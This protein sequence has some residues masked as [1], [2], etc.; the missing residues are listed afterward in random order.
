MKS[1]ALQ[2]D[3]LLRVSAAGGAEC[4]GVELLARTTVLL[5]HLQLDGQPVAVPTRDVGRVEPVER[6]RLDDDVLENLVDGM[7]DVNGAVG[8]RRSIVQH[9][10]RPATGTPRGSSRR[11]RR[12][13]HSFTIRGLAL[14]EVRLH[15]E[16]GLRQV[17]RLFVLS[18]MYF[19]QTFNMRRA[20]AASR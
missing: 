13:S 7:A 5:L 20:C 12:S 17:D 16:V 3:L 1:V 18:A 14:R 2:I 4:G 6:A 9:E 19:V 15:G 8:V 11:S 10:T